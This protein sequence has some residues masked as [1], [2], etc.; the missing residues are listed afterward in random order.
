[1][2]LWKNN[3]KGQV[4]EALHMTE[5]QEQLVKKLVTEKENTPDIPADWHCKTR[6]VFQTRLERMT[7]ELMR[8]GI[9][10]MRAYVISAVAGEIGNNS[11][12]HNIGN[13]RDVVGVWFSFDIFADGKVKVILA[14]RG[15]GVLE[16]L[17]RVKT[18][19]GTDAEALE[20]AF[21]E[22]LSG[23]APENRGNGLKFV[24]SMVNTH[25]LRLTFAS[26]N[27]TMMLEAGMKIFSSENVYG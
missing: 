1:M 11:F 24:R 22:K 2:L 9:D 25:G 3:H 21:T 4:I 23:R 5:N 19:L 20:T 15:R 8:R 16:T 27:A 6:D 18:S 7:G 10:E 13:W 26:G 12:D 14:D 17:R